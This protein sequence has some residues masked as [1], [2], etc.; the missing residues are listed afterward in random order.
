MKLNP[1]IAIVGRPNV[2]KSTLFNKIIGR[3]ISIVDDV[4]GVTRDRIYADTD[5]TNKN[6]TLVDTG[7]IIKFDKDIINR[8]VKI[9]AKE[10]IDEADAVIFMVDGKEGLTSSDEEVASILRVSQKPVILTVNKVDNFNNIPNEVYD[11]YS[12]GFGEPVL[13]SAAA[14]LNIGD[15]LDTLVEKLPETEEIQYDDDI[16]KI[17]VVG[18]PNVGKS[19]I[20]NYIIGKERS[21]VSEIPGTTRDAIDTLFKKN[22]KDY[23]FIDTAGMR[24]K[25]KV[26]ENVEYYSVMRGIRAI[27]RSDLALLVIDASEGVTEQDKRIAG[28][29]HEAGKASIIVVNKWDLVDKDHTTHQIYQQEIR[30]SFLFLKYAPIIFVSA[31]TGRRV[32]NIID[33]VDEVYEQYSIRITTGMLNR[34][35]LAATDDVEPPIFK[36]RRLKIYYVTGGFVD[37]W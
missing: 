30:N 14:A 15:L 27:K 21:I 3:R 29:V 9:Q 7:G 2:G 24:R 33:I 18:R 13:I 16:V 32:N 25:S 23:V 4:P 1:I 20:I 26:T 6:F 34:I 36:G 28:L 31:K 17:A 11:F 8:Q 19:S 35:I 5:W 37:D 12:L 22:E 10:A